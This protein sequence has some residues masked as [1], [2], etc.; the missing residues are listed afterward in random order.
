MGL[1]VQIMPAQVEL[2]NQN[3]LLELDGCVLGDCGS[4][5]LVAGRWGRIALGLPAC[6]VEAA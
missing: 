6:N 1:T 5:N 4:P 2:G 3:D